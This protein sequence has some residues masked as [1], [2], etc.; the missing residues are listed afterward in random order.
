MYTRDELDRALRLLGQVLQD[1]GLTYELAVIGG[2]ALAMI[3]LID[4]STK[5]LDVVALVHD[6]SIDSAEPLPPP[7]AEAI[8]DVANELSLN[9]QWLNSGPTSMIRFGLP[10]GFL[11]RCS[12]VDYGTLT[13]RLA[14]RLDQIH[15]KLYATADDR[16]AG[17]HHRDLVALEPT[18]TELFQAAAWARPHDPSPGFDL[19]VRQVLAAFGITEG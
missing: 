14:S 16:P 9:P 6:G 15:F 7:L 3:G 5:D 2:G 18:S 11:S 1:R 19:M 8:T 13:I 10:V 12:R 17:K 4:R